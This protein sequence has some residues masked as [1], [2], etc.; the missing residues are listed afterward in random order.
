[1]CTLHTVTHAV[2]SL[3]L[4]LLSASLSLQ[5]P[6]AS[7]ASWWQTQSQCSCSQPSRGASMPRMARCRA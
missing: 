7:K 6:E 2:I 4:S 1:M 5:V 3:P